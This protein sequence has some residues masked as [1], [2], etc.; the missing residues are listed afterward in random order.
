MQAS[1]AIIWGEEYEKKGSYTERPAQV[2]A[3][4]WYEHKTKGN[5]V[6]TPRESFEVVG[7]SI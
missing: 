1:A 3:E 6:N 4:Q 7:L 5:Y 2:L